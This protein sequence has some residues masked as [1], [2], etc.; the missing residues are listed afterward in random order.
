MW[1]PV[2]N[3]RIL[4]GW[5]VPPLDAQSL[6]REVTWNPELQQLCYNPLTEQ[7]ALRST[8]LEVPPGGTELRSGV[9]L[10][11]GP[12][13]GSVGNQWGHCPPALSP[14]PPLPLSLSS[15][16][17]LPLS[18]SLFRPPLSRGSEL[19][20]CGVATY[21]LCP[22]AQPIVI[23]ATTVVLLAHRSEITVTFDLPTAATTLGL[24]VM[25]SGDTKSSGVFF[26][27]EWPDP[28]ISAAAG[29]GGGWPRTVTVGAMRNRSGYGNFDIIFDQFSRISQLRPTQHAL[30]A[31]LYLVTILIGG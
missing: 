29:D 16:P 9:P 25:A 8:A 24:V 23:C 12:W 11:L 28:A 6:P 2:G 21:R 20:P 7:E 27:I 4:W 5:G 1:D 19:V 30:Y 15:S 26:F 31:I 18:L 17:S 3:R 10:P 13:P 22:H 14:S